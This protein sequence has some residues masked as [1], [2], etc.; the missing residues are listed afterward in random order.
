MSTTNTENTTY[1]KYFIPADFSQGRHSLSLSLIK[2]RHVQHL[3]I[4]DMA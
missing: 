1:R 4:E 2:I 3:T